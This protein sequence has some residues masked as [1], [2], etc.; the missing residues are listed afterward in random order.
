MARLA[1]LVPQ[2][3]E[4]EVEDPEA[5]LYWI[6]PSKTELDW[7]GGCG[8]L[9]E[10]WGGMTVLTVKQSLHVTPVLNVKQ[11]IGGKTVMP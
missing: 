1:G 10:T 5:D 4:H 7:V 6:P 8:E 2:F 11:L 3:A 9:P